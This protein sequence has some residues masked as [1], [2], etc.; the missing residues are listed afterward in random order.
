MPGLY[1]NVAHHCK[2]IVASAEENEDC[3]PGSEKLLQQLDLKAAANKLVRHIVS[4]CRIP[5][6]SLKAAAYP[7]RL[8]AAHP[9]GLL[10]G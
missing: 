3:R 10:T 9:V 1:G 2:H 4:G 8:F 6:W 7:H 5:N